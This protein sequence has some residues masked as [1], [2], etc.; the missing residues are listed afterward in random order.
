MENMIGSG[1]T[2]RLTIRFGRVYYITDDEFYF[3]NALSLLMP[4]K[5]EER[6][7]SAFHG[8]L[9]F[10]KDQLH[11]FDNMRIMN[12]ENGEALCDSEQLSDFLIRTDPKTTPNIG[13]EKS[14]IYV[15]GS[16]PGLMVAPSGET[17][18]LVRGNTIFDSLKGEIA[19]QLN[20][21]RHGEIS[22]AVFY[23]GRLLLIVDNAVYDG[24]SEDIIECYYSK[25][26]DS[27]VFFGNLYLLVNHEMIATFGDDKSVFTQPHTPWISAD[28]H[29]LYAICFENDYAGFGPKSAK[30]VSD[31]RGKDHVRSKIIK[32]SE[33]GSEQELI[34][35]YKGRLVSRVVSTDEN[36]YDG[37]LMGRIYNTNERELVFDINS[38]DR[39]PRETDQSRYIWLIFNRTN[40]DVI[41]N[42]QSALEMKVNLDG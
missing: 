25:I 6:I 31:Y 14:P 7:T 20:P 38:W 8:P 35:E 5:P 33:D 19:R 2:D 17:V 24:F 16:Y 10:F 23:D 39:E 34:A 15:T 18:Y 26:N 28:G 36:V 37:D 42:Q 41:R 21:L 30:Q 12:L 4:G 22:N 40:A 29:S 27:C 32:L 13:D 11:G 9:F 1:I 3:N